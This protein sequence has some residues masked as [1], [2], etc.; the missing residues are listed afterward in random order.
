MYK[1]K[2]FNIGCVAVDHLNLVPA[3]L[4][5]LGCFTDL[6]AVAVVIRGLRQRMNVRLFD[7]HVR[8]RLHSVAHVMDVKMTTD[9]R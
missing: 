5:T 2:P 6:H 4:Q 7:A 1:I 8:P 3:L 9:E